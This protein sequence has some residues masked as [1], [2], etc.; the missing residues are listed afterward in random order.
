LIRQGASNF[1]TGITSGAEAGTGDAGSVQVTARDLQILDGG[2][3]RSDTFSSGDAGSVTVR[4][5]HLLIRRGGTR[6]TSISSSAQRG[7]GDAGSVQVAAD[8]L[9]ILDGGTIAT[10][11]FA[12]GKAGDIEIEA[13]RLLIQRSGSEFL[14][15]ITSSAQAGAR[16]A[17]SVRIAARE[18]AILGGGQIVS[19]TF[20][21][22]A[23]GVV[24]VEADRV[25]IRGPASG[26]LSSAGISRTGAVGLGDA[27]SVRIDADRVAIDNGGIVA[28]FAD[29]PGKA[30]DVILRAADRL[31][32]DEGSITTSTAVG[33]G[34][35]IQLLVGGVIDLRDSAVIT[36]VA[37]GADPTAGSITIDPKILIIDGSRIQADAPAGFGGRVTIVADNILVPGGDFEALLAR[38]EIS[39]SGGDPT[40]AGTIAV[41]APEVDLSAG[42]VVLEGAL[43]D[44]APLGERCGARRDI[45][46]SSFTGVGRAGLP[47][48]PDG[49]LASLY[50]TSAGAFEGVESRPGTRPAQ[51]AASDVRLAGLIRPCAPL[52]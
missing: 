40:R 13:G 27:G 47:P 10:A 15:G 33:G 38:G 7:T 23:A 51:A 46:A 2:R 52:D 11:T 41:N 34:G 42:L 43:L 22:G 30:G 9:E 44:S 12:E 36:S 3:I 18:V 4:A 26:V 20:A 45:G 17:G 48:T 35:E 37:G 16:D 1:F 8:V 50:L 28:S 32:L 31:V 14:T 39:A 21:A 5:D 24:T 6:S 19:A 25:L 49:P 29:G